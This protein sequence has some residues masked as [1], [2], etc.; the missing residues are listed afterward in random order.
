MKKPLIHFAC[1]ALMLLSFTAS[2]Q[3]ISAIRAQ[4]N[5]FFKPLPASMPGSENDSA[6]KI[7]LGE[8]LY[9]ETALS[10]NNTQSCNSCHLLDEGK[11]A[12]VDNLRVSPGAIEGKKGDRNSP[13]VWNAGFHF[14]Q[15]WD[16]RAADL[17][18]QA[19]GPILN[20]VEMAIPDEATA[21]KNLKA[22]GYD[23][24]FNKVFGT[25]NALTY[26]NIAEAIAAFERTLITKDRFDDFLKGDDKAL[27]EKELAGLQKFISSG[28]IAC[29]T[30]PLLGGNMYQKM[31]L[32]NAYPNKED[33]GRFTET[34]KA[35]DM[36]MFKVPSLR[37]IAQT[38]PYFHDGAAETLEQAVS[39]MA[40]YQLGQKL[41]E[42]TTASIVAFLKTMDN[43]REFK[44]TTS[45]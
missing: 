10:V 33:K 43:Q 22:A 7:A 18:E 38:A 16:G 35:S 29:H 3:D 1:A 44:R 30:G 17:K 6:E 39:D 23:A 24:E 40:W 9:F 32:V 28:C 4:A 26:D 42:E 13:T 36:Y 14:V 45:N 12:G 15:F 5:T 20:P 41:D 19:K 21:V 31:G 37:N 34:Q 2:A 11:K 27:T 25:K 8:K